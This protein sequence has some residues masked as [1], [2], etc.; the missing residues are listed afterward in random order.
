MNRPVADRSDADVRP[1]GRAASGG[2]PGRVNRPGEGRGLFLAGSASCA[3][4][5]A[6]KGIRRGQGP[7]HPHQGTYQPY[8]EPSEAGWGM[9]MRPLP[10]A[11][12]VHPG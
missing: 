8:S 1:D 6:G 12:T 5:E 3:S 4:G 7:L 9:Q 10:F 2:S 11:S